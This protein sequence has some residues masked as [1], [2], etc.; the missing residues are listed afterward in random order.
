MSS[1]TRII[2]MLRH[3]NRP[4]VWFDFETATMDGPPVE[5]AMVV[6]AAEDDAEDHEDQTTA[7]V[8]ASLDMPISYAVSQRLNPGCQISPGAS[9]VHGI[10]NADVAG[11]PSFDDP[12]IVGLFRAFEDMGAIFCGHNVAAFDL[13]IAHACGYIQGPDMLDTMRIAKR[14][15]AD[16]PMPHEH[17]K[18]L[19]ESSLIGLGLDAFSLS[20]TGLHVAM[21]GQRFDGAHGAL[22]D[23][24]ANVRVFQGLMEGWLTEEAVINYQVNSPDPIAVFLEHVNTPPRTQVGWTGWLG[25]VDTETTFDYEFKRGKHK[26]LTVSQVQARHPDYIQWMLGPKGPDDLDEETRAILS[27]EIPF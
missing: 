6:M 25:I 26:G 5:F 17:G 10:T 7:E 16:F 19:S 22:A 27:D 8:A 4:L 23:V 13:P 9:A 3:A 1:F 12:E 20:L 11:C 14:L 15:K 2:D 24:I 21:T 18:A